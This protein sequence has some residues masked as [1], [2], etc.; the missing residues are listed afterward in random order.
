M[1]EQTMNNNTAEEAA[2]IE[3]GRKQFV[4]MTQTPI[5]RLI[6]GLGIPTM[7]SMMVTSLYNLADTAFVSHLG[8]S[9]TAAISSL[10]ALM[11]IIQA[12]GFT[13]GMGSGSLVSSLLGK[14]D[15]EGAD[16]T[17]SSALFIAAASGLLIMAFGMI[18]LEPIMKLFGASSAETLK[19]AKDYAR[20]ILIAAPFMCMS[21]VLNN[22]LRAEGKAVFSM[23]GLIVGAVINV[24]L[25]PI[26]IF[27]CGMKVAGA[28]LATCISQIISF[29]VMLFVFL[30]KRK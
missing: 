8:D 15:R 18:F 4:K 20:Y 7:L 23:V 24:G 5:P 9:A 22:V 3:G 27:A 16:R 30:S 11:S 10:L 25:D 17:A 13:Y 12:I 14:R 1:N 26:L 2:V 28:G 6:I 29:G 21:Y 19:Y